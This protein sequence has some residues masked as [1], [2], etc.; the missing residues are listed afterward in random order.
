MKAGINKS[1]CLP[2]GV[3]KKIH[4]IHGEYLLKVQNIFPENLEKMELVFI[5]VD[6]LPVPF[7]IETLRIKNDENV[8][9]KFEGINVEE[10]AREFCGCSVLARKKDIQKLKNQEIRLDALTGYTII[11]QTA[12]SV[13]KI[14]EI[15]NNE[16]N[17]LFIVKTEKKELLIPV[18]ED[19]ILHLDEE[20]KE[21][22]MNLPDGLLEI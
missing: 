22:E 4:G 6:E 9:I 18:N 15:N 20:K 5:D 7:F 13:G 3:L 1:D 17:P 8:F 12:G 16:N 2:I 14:T 10:K 21:I 11:D 19:F